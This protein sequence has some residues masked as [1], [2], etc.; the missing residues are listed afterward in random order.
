MTTLRPPSRSTPPDPQRPDKGRERHGFAAIVPLTRMFAPEHRDSLLLIG[1]T[2]FLVAF[3]LVDQ[4][5]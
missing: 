5:M 4:P 2:L 1:V 3:G